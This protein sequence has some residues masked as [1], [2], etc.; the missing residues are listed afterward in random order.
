MEIELNKPV[1]TK[2]SKDEIVMS[3]NKE[4]KE[5]FFRVN[6]EAQKKEF[7]MKLAIVNDLLKKF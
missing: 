2:I 4:L 1:F 5:T 7:E 3:E 6:L